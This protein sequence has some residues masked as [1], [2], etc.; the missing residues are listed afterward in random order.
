MNQ[1]ILLCILNSLSS[2]LI[3][4]YIILF[5]LLSRTT[6][7]YVDPNFEACQPQTCGNQTISY[8]FFIQGR[9]E[10]FCGYPGFGIS[11][12]KD[13]FPIL[14]LSNTPYIID[15]IFYDNDSFRVSNAVF[16]R[17][18]TNNAGC[19]SPTRNLT[20]PS[21]N[22]FNLVPNQK[23]IILFFGC[24][25]SSMPRELIEYRIGCSE[26]KETSS[27]LA[28]HKEDKLL[29]S[30]VSK[31]CKG[32]VVD[33]VVEDG[34][35]GIEEALRKGFLLNWTASDCS[36]CRST[37][38]RCGFNSTIFTFRCYCTDRVH[39]SNCHTG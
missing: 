21:T 27:V 17:S 19:L 2:P 7:C 20:L 26:E 37:G 6:L 32:E 16:S 36:L 31:S 9:Q 11:C 5:S 35:E 12:G 30:V 33:A 1:K 39:A 8:P 25:L 23:D 3:H 15:Q 13:G 24:D 22:K 14:N 28:L 29:I 38:G 10:P 4:S 34:E 18:S